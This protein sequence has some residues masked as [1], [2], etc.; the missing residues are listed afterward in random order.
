LA[1][2]RAFSIAAKRDIS[3]YT[4]IAEIVSAVAIV[5]SLL[6]A[7]N[8]FRQ[9]NT[10][11]TREADLILF[12]RVANE[13]REIVSTPGL[14]EIL[15]AA[16]EDP[17]DL[18]PADRVRFLAFQHNFFDSWEIAWEYHHSGILDAETWEGWDAWF[19]KEARERPAF[20]WTENRD[21]FTG[22]AF[23]NHVEA[24]LAAK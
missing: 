2:R 21:D 9:S 14:A 24:Q 18:S 11:S 23:R 19:S 12:E 8:E 7:A 22:E 13:N 17:D 5:I 1:N 16:S 20:G 4:S 15:V 6:Y 10:L 3:F